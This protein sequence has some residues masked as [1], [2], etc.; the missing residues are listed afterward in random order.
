MQEIATK[1]NP[2]FVNKS[3]QKGNQNGA[4]WANVRPNIAS[5]M[6]SNVGQIFYAILD[7]FGNDLG[8]GFGRVLER[9]GGDFLE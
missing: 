8:G 2:I 1:T 3:H 4:C 9:F 5:K 6:I 7:R